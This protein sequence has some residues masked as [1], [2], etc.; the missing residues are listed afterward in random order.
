MTNVISW[1]NHVEVHRRQWLTDYFMTAACSLSHRYSAGASI[2]S[3]LTLVW[4]PPSYL[5]QHWYTPTSQ[6][7]INSKIPNHPIDSHTC[8]DTRSPRVGVHDRPSPRFAQGD[9]YVPL[10]DSRSS[11]SVMRSIASSVQCGSP[12]MFHL[13]IISS[14]LQHSLMVMM[15][16][17]MMMPCRVRLWQWVPC[18]R[19]CR[20]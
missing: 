10:E 14:S 19:K 1:Q 17:P 18:L 9:D 3:S 2:L 20:I 7:T 4:E 15:S 16:M 11:Y 13:V 12:F 8:K 6:K 5:G